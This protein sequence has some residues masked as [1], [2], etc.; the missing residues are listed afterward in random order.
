MDGAKVFVLAQNPGVD[1]ESQGRPLVGKTGQMFEAR[2]LPLAKLERGVNVS[3]GN[4]LKCRWQ[5]GSK[6]IN[7]LPPAA[8]LKPAVEHCTRE[9]L[10]IPRGTELVIGMGKLA[11]DYLGCPGS[12]STWRGFTYEF[13][14]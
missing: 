9:H 11:N 6:R 3:L 8:I 13:M 5:V 7:N 1:E 12:V 14:G 10:I 2:F 4:V